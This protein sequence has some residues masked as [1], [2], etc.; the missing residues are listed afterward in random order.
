MIQCLS[1]IER[2]KKNTENKLTNLRIKKA[3]PYF[4]KVIMNL[5]LRA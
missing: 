4:S 2:F 3:C 1:K 5:F